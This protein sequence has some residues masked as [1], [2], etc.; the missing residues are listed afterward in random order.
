MIHLPSL[1]ILLTGILFS[2]QINA[3]AQAHRVKRPRRSP[4][5][6]VSQTIGLSTI[7][8]RYSRPAAR[9]RK[10]WGN[11][12]PFGMQKSNFGERGPMPWRAGANENTVF[13]ISDDVAINGK[14]LS[15]G[16]YGLH[17]IVQANNQ[18]TV[19]FSKNYTSWG[20]FF[21]NAQDDAL[22]IQSKLEDYPVHVERLK[23]EFENISNN[24][25]TVSLYWGKKKISFTVSL[26]VHKIVL[27]SMKDELKNYPGFFWEGPLS[28]AQYCVDNKVALDQ[29][30]EWVNQS[31]KI[32]STFANNREKASILIRQGKSDQAM[33]YVD[34]ALPLGTIFQLHGLGRELIRFKLLKKAMEVFS[35]NYKKHKDTP[36][37]INFGMMRGHSALGQYKKALKYA[38][39]ALEHVPPHDKSNQRQLAEAIK[40]LKNNQD[41]N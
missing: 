36:V 19:I 22:R 26:D 9:K 7:T 5:A 31:I 23:Y 27:A 2:L 14:K 37:T 24:S 35:Y 28:A 4:A 20:S 34:K 6:Q 41:V 1:K 38:K 10:V 32:K 33:A 30:L 3:F 21:Y 16:S 11:V 40:K 25:T 39:A 17:M 29:A 13:A 18:V 8:I 12:V 15:A